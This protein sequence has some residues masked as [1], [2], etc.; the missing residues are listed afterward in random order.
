MTVWVTVTVA[1]LAAPFL[2]LLSTLEEP[3]LELLAA[4]V[5][6]DLLLALVAVAWVDLAASD[7]TVEELLFLFLLLLD[8]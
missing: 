1:A 6:L 2:S 8:R 4:V 5:V 7:L 3:V